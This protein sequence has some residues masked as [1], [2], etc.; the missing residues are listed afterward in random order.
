VPV[1]GLG[2]AVIRITDDASLAAIPSRVPGPVLDRF[3][4]D[5]IDSGVPARRIPELP[6]ELVRAGTL[7]ATASWPFVVHRHMRE[8]ADPW[9]LHEAPALKQGLR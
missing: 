6:E 7:L 3:H 8:T 9:S 1:K 2:C 5:E 4:S